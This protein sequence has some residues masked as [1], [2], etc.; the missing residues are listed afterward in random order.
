MFELAH[1]QSALYWLRNVGHGTAV[2]VE[3]KLV[4]SHALGRKL[5]D[6]REV[7][8]PRETIDFLIPSP[9]QSAVVVSWSNPNDPGGERMERS[10]RPEVN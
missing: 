8:H 4:G 3:A 6:R 5:E 1:V 9:M 7:L 2:D 10:V